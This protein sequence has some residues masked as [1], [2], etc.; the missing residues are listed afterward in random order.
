[1]IEKL[2]NEMISSKTY[3]KTLKIGPQTNLSKFLNDVGPFVESKQ[4]STKQFA[5]KIEIRLTS[6]SLKRIK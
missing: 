3:L 1:M 6:E 2:I 5:D 4:I